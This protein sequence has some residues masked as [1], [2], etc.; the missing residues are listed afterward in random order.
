MMKSE[1]IFYLLC[2]QAKTTS[3][4]EENVDDNIDNS[5]IIKTARSSFMSASLDNKQDL[6]SISPG[7]EGRETKSVDVV[8]VEEEIRELTQVFYYL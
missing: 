1:L 6:D 2:E 4:K 5:F 7:S 3:R 8:Q